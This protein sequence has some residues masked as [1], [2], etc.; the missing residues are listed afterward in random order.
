MK[1]PD[2][3]IFGNKAPRKHLLPDRACCSS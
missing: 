2:N 1:K 3:F